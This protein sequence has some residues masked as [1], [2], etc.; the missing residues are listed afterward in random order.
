MFLFRSLPVMPLPVL[1]LLLPLAAAFLPL[2]FYIY[3]RIKCWHK[4]EECVCEINLRFLKIFFLA[5]LSANLFLTWSVWTSMGKGGTELFVLSS[6][7]W[8]Q[9]LSPDSPMLIKT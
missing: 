9:T 5:V 4:Y 3:K 7:G 2:G 6:G 1:S 8:S